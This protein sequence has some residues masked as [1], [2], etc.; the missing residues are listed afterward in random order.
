MNTVRAAAA[1][2]A[3]E[4]AVELVQGVQVTVRQLRYRFGP[5]WAIS[6]AYF[7]SALPHTGAVG[8]WVEHACMYGALLCATVR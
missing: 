5:F 2:P 8:D 7:S 4:D 1:E 3:A 6:D